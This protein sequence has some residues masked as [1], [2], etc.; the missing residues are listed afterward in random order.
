[1]SAPGHPL[2]RRLVFVVAVVM[3]T[4]CASLTL[5]QDRD[6]LNEFSRAQL[7]APV[8]ALDTEAARREAGAE[9]DRL[10]STPLSSD[11]TVRIALMNSPALQ[12]ALAQNAA[13]S[14]AATQSARLPNP[15]FTFEWLTRTEDGLVQKDIGRKLTVSLFDLLTLPRR[16]KMAEQRQLQLRI[17]VAGDVLG[18]A[19]EARQA[20]VRAVAA[21]QS[22]AY[23]EQ[24]M[25]AA[26]VS[27]ELARRMQAVGNYSRLQRAREQAFYADA[28]AQ[29][30]RA[31][32]AAVTAREVLVR[33]I[34]LD[35]SQAARLR[36]P[37]RLPELP[38]TARDEASVVRQAME[39]RLDI[40]L[41]RA[42]LESTAGELGLTQATS[43]ISG[44]ELSGIRI[45]E[46]G[47][48]SWRGYE[49]EFPLPLFDFGDARRAGAQA[50]Y[51]AALNRTAQIAVDAQ[52][53]TREGFMGYRTSYEL[54]RHYRDEIVP[55]RRAIADE[56]LLKY[57]GMLI[58]VFDL[59][60]DAREQIGAVMQALD[61]QRDFWLADAALQA[62]L[63]G[64][65]AALP[66]SETTSV[67]AAARAH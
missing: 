57:N 58:G 3:L 12:I 21:Q 55:L 52:S 4:G 10:L 46:S 15:L 35:E 31:R 33:A 18:V 48:P 51:M 39:Q 59:L 53:Q 25:Q 60:A 37:A 63:L 26:E 20:W 64:R 32:Y 44:F 34:G 62:T 19:V 47:E 66:A 50:S 13:A 42:Q 45:S 17:Q 36:L 1:M 7:G 49:L 61:A 38:G 14:A 9:V 67:R 29:F 23:V 27:A 8:K 41:A 65:P 54:A 43:F 24:V 2:R 28:A 56:M 40:R 22:L 11:D 30:A 5:D 6:A 16:M